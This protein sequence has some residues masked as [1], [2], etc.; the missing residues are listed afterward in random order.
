MD[1]KSYD[2]VIVGGGPGGYSSAI[3]AARYNMKILVIVKERGGLITKTHLVENYP[4]FKSLTGFELMDNIENHVNEYG[5]EIIDDI[6]VDSKKNKDGEFE[7]LTESGKSFVTKAIILA[8]GS[9]RRKL[10]VK[11]EKDFDGKGV[12]YCATCDGMFFRGKDVCVIGGSD[13]AAKEA[14]MLSEHCKK[15]YIIYRGDKLRAE[16][17]NMNRVLKKDNIEIVYGSNLKEVVGD[18]VVSG[19]VLDNDYKGSNKINLQGV[20]IEIG[21]IPNSSIAKRLG[22]DLT[23]GG[24]IIV[25]RTQRTSVEKV[26]AIGDVTDFAFRQ[27]IVATSAGS[28]ASWS[29]FN[30][31]N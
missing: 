11:G 23:S 12:S 30:D 4:G 3:Y 26:Y 31:L 8:T 2:L 17:I 27:A 1:D 7:V 5:V 20:F 25:D 24:E 13:S 29:A 19:V 21:Q 28:V 16:P 14:L 22:C 18:T 9:N 10:D 6:V 15:V